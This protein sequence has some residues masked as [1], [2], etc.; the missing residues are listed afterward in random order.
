M[1]EGAFVLAGEHYVGHW[2]Q[3]CVEAYVCVL[4]L[5]LNL[6]THQHN[7]SKQN[8]KILFP[9]FWC[10][11]LC[12]NSS[13]VLAASVIASFLGF[14]MEQKRQK[15]E[16]WW[17][18]LFLWRC[19]Y[20]MPCTRECEVALS[21]TGLLP[22]MQ[23]V[24]PRCRFKKSC[25]SILVKLHGVWAGQ[26]PGCCLVGLPLLFYDQGWCIHLR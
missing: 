23:V 18:I 1:T 15:G 19:Y 24:Q 11:F 21:L 14:W 20:N 12:V 25:P 6:Q 8:M 4:N 22:C 5:C 26:F 2:C 10:E 17:L 16:G 13:V 9:L 7:I 3:L